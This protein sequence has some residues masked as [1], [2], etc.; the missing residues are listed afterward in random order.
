VKIRAVSISLTPGFSPVKPIAS[1]KNRFNGFL[2]AI[3]PLKRLVRDVTPH[4]RLKPG[5]DQR[6]KGVTCLCEAR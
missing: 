6:S 1:T 5:V 2:T 3:K 4:T